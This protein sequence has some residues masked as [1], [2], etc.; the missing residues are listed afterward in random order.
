MKAKAATAKPSLA[1]PPLAAWP[2]RG[3]C[4][5]PTSNGAPWTFCQDPTDPASPYGYCAQHQART[6]Q[7]SPGSA[8]GAIKRSDFTL[9]APTSSSQARASKAGNS[10]GARAARSATAARKRGEQP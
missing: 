7:R 9:P 10:Y 3:R 5:W 8:A 1:A 4:C 2:E 6:H